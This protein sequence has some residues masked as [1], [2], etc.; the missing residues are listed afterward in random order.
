MSA[1]QRLIY[2]AAVDFFGGPYGPRMPLLFSPDLDA[3]WAAFGA[4]LQRTSLPAPARELAILVTARCW[5]SQFEWYAHEPM[6]VNAGLSQEIVDAV[7]IGRRPQSE[8]PLIGAIFDY[9]TAL[10]KHRAVHDAVYE[11]LRELLGPEQLTILTVF[12]GY[13]SN[14][15]ISLAAHAAPLPNGGRPPLPS[16]Y[17]G[18]DLRS[19]RELYAQADGAELY[20][21]CDGDPLAPPLLL[22][23]S[24]GT[25]ITMWEPQMRALTEHF[26]VIRYDYRGHGRSDVTPG[27]Y[28]LD[29]LGLDALAVL[30][31]VGVER[32]RGCGVSLG[33]MIGQWLGINAPSRVDGLV[34]ANSSSYIGGP[35]QVRP[36]IEAVKRDGVA[37]IVDA[38]VPRWFTP[39]FI[40]RDARQVERIKRVFSSIPTEGYAGCCAALGDLDFRD[41][42]GEINVPTIVIGGEY[43]PATPPGE[44]A[45]MAKAIPRA[46]LLMLPAAHLSN[47]EQAEQFIQAVIDLLG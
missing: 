15:A 47:V 33:G 42:L 18:D 19:V 29:R 38:I 26:M 10:L 39:A 20:V 1:S 3:V 5:D 4:E 31:A 22:S 8:D 24:L 23:N 32:V 13:Y 45:R 2:D 40:E 14:V 46:R 36:R 28:T 44:A 30:D 34:I 25:D 17:G 27:P 7:R 11:R 9:V 12:V 35:E 21:R 6:A 37:S 41:R 43:D 16:R